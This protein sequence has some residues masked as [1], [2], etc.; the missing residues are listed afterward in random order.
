MSI[1]LNQPNP[2]FLKSFPTTVISNAKTVVPQMM[3]PGLFTG[4][5]FGGL[6]AGLSWTG[7]SKFE[8]TPSTTALFFGLMP[9]V[10]QVTQATT[11]KITQKIFKSYMSDPQKAVEQIKAQ[12]SIA[13]AIAGSCIPI[14]NTAVYNV[15]ATAMELNQWDVSEVLY[16]QFCVT[17]YYS[18]LIS[19]AGMMASTALKTLLTAQGSFEKETQSPTPNNTGPTIAELKNA[20]AKPINQSSI[21]MTQDISEASEP[22]A[23][24]LKENIIKGNI[25]KGIAVA[26]ALLN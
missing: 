18:A 14:L 23:E 4:L 7:M 8:G 13:L 19:G 20:D 17:L 1:T 9:A 22:I 5:L 10:A 15:F 21:P 16:K 26:N 11:S 6:H 3:V 2:H 25:E 12:Q 24:D